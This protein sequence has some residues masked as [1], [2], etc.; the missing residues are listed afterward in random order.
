MKKRKDEPRSS[1]KKKR[2][3]ETFVKETNI[4]L[5]LKLIY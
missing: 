2:A 4:L 5:R 1:V 3:T